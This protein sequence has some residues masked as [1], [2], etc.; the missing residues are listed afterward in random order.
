MAIITYFYGDYVQDF[1]DVVY[2]NW[3]LF[4]YTD[5]IA[6]NNEESSPAILTTKSLKQDFDSMIEEENWTEC[7]FETVISS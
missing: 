1:E 4:N 5:D 6:D 3:S 2:A 7:G